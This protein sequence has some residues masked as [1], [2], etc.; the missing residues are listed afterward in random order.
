MLRCILPAVQ[1]YASPKVPGTQYFTQSFS[2]AVY[3]SN[4]RRRVAFIVF[5]DD[6]TR[7]TYYEKEHDV[8]RLVCA[9][10]VQPLS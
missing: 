2:A 9:H 3:S 5:G 7:N 1:R 10:F 6:M 4:G 8:I